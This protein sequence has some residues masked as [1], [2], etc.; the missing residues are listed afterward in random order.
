MGAPTVTTTEAVSTSL[1]EDPDTV[2]LGAS[3]GVTTP[4]QLARLRPVVLMILRRR[5]GD[6]VTAEDFCSEAFKIVLE[7][8]EGASL[9][10]PEKLASFVCQ[11]ARNLAVA[12]LRKRARRQTL[13][14]EEWSIDNTPTNSPGPADELQHSWRTEAVR[15][16]LRE[17]P[18]AR[19]RELLVRFY[20]DDEDRASICADLGL[21][22]T[23]FNKVIFRARQRFRALIERRYPKSDLL[24]VVVGIAVALT[25][26]GGAAMRI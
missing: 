18:S 3:S 6:T 7:R 26:S 19:D 9:Q 11:T 12:E 16:V 8:L 2:R 14:G 5:L 4:V 15:R 21:T 20:I 24:S 25:C 22:E 10:E 17:L 23:H 1:I 13:T